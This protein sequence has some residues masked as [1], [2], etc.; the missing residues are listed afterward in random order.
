MGRDERT[1]QVG[2]QRI[3]VSE[4]DATVKL[5]SP[6]R[7]P[8]RLAGRKGTGRQSRIHELRSIGIG[9]PGGKAHERKQLLGRAVHIRERMLDGLKASD[10]AP[11]LLA[12]LYIF[13]S[14]LYYPAGNPCE[15]GRE[16]NPTL[17]Q[18]GHVGLIE[19]RQE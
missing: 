9:T 7:N 4:P 1:P 2:V 11:E 17:E 8:R 16:S 18:R 13:H 10:W 5:N 15:L 14:Q 19:H 6:L 12:S 3:L